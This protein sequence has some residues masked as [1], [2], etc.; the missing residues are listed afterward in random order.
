MRFK[1]P[2]ITKIDLKLQFTGLIYG[3]I[4]RIMLAYSEGDPKTRFERIWMSIEGLEA[5]LTYYHDK[6]YALGVRKH[7]E[8]INKALEKMDALKKVLTHED[9]QNTDFLRSKKKF[10]ELIKLIG[11]AGF[12]PD[13]DI[14]A[15]E[16]D[17]IYA[18]SPSPEQT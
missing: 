8:D 2:D 15:S 14:G 13:Q 18:D 10:E 5:L 12:Y 16:E 6:L 17:D 1:K 3:Q 11:R 7:E 9:L 4:N